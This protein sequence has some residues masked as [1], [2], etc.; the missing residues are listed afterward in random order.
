VCLFGRYGR[1]GR[2]VSG[3]E[4]SRL[5]L[6]AVSGTGAMFREY[7]AQCRID[8]MCGPSAGDE[9]PVCGRFWG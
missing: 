9:A 1:S 3:F 5:A 6:V 7:R 2:G 8:F 4:R